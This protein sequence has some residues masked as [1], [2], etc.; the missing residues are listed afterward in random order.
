MRTIE[1]DQ[2]STQKHWKQNADRN[3]YLNKL[4]NYLIKDGND[5]YMRYW[6]YHVANAADNYPIDPKTAT[7]KK[8]YDC[9]CPFHKMF[10]DDE[11]EL[12]F[13]RQP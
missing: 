6:L 10:S 9:T 3:N 8:N 4:H 7:L 2:E 13:L 11:L 5:S 12:I 1:C